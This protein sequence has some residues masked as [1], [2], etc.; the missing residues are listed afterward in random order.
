MSPKM[1]ENSSSNGVVWDPKAD[2]KIL[3]IAGQ[4]KMQETQAE[5][6]GRLCNEI[7]ELQE[8]KGGR[9]YGDKTFEKMAKDPR[10]ACAERQLRRYWQYYRLLNV[11]PYKDIAVPEKLK[12]KK[13]IIYQLARIMQEKN[14]DENAKIE[15]ISECVKEILKTKRLV[16]QAEDIVDQAIAGKLPLSSGKHSKPMENKSKF[17]VSPEKIDRFTSSLKKQFVENQKLGKPH[18]YSVYEINT[19]SKLLNVAVDF[20]EASMAH[21][22]KQEIIAYMKPIAERISRMA[23]LNNNRK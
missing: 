8:G 13:C 6:I 1:I 12:G 19:Y 22:G 18:D 3:E 14:L 23:G 16:S 4:L 20:L 9:K 11:A 10:I 5:S 2:K 15:L 17:F 21:K 7:I